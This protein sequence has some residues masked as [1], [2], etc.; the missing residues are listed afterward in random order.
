M[1]CYTVNGK[2]AGAKETL[3]VLRVALLLMCDMKPSEHNRVSIQSQVNNENN[4][5]CKVLLNNAF[6]R[7]IRKRL[8]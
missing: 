5:K 2:F 1:S 3:A 7:R 8:I 4:Y 6:T